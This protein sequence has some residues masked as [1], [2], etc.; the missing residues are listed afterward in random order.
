MI[1]LAK[2]RYLV[3]TI[4]PKHDTTPGWRRGRIRKCFVSEKVNGVGLII[5]K[6]DFEVA[7]H[8]IVTSIPDYFLRFV[9]IKS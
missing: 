3:R 5:T 4:S 8:Y 6:I 9:P 7:S 2:C 1:V